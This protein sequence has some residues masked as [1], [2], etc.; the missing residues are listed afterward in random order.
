MDALTFFK[1]AKGFRYINSFA[2]TV[3][4][5]ARLPIF[6][7]SGRASWATQSTAT[8]MIRCVPYML[9]CVVAVLS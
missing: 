8:R 3:Q 5:S 4:A 6:S 7:V 9:R 1:L 2:V